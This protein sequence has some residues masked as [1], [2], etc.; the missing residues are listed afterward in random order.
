M[1]WIDIYRLLKYQVIFFSLCDLLDNLVGALKHLLQLLVLS[2]IQVLLKFAASALKVAILID[3]LLLARHALSLRQGWRFTLKFV[4]HGL[5]CRP[6]IHKLLLALG[7]LLL[8][9]GLRRFG[10]TRLFED[11]IGADK[12]DTELLCLS[13]RR[14]EQNTQQDAGT[15]A[16]E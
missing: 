2:R 1:F 7:E 10:G 3:Q 9:L 11:A 16:A 15:A 8:K 6:E 12:S 13:V 14:H 4:C 5:Q